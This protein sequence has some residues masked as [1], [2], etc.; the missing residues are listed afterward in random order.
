MGILG[1]WRRIGIFLLMLM[2]SKEDGNFSEQEP[3]PPN[4]R[5]LEKGKIW[6]RLKGRF[7]DLHRGWKIGAPKPI[8]SVS[9]IVAFYTL[10]YL[11]GS[12]PEEI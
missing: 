8:Q 10:L 5:N 9:L 3:S 6:E 1:R 7:Q 4:V 2:P 11:Q 12:L